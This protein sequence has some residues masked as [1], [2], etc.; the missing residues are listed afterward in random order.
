MCIRDS[1]HTACVPR[2]AKNIVTS[3]TGVKRP[4]RVFVV[5]KWLYCRGRLFSG[6][7]VVWKKGYICFF[8]VYRGFRLL[9][10]PVIIFLLFLLEGPKAL[11]GVSDD[12]TDDM[13]KRGI[14]TRKYE[15]AEKRLYEVWACLS[16]ENIC[17]LNSTHST[18][19]GG[20]SRTCYI[21]DTKYELWL[22]KR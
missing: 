4:L 18:S 12:S 2:M 15:Q 3:G 21:C 9:W 16:L 6:P 8:S 20:G 5:L 14:S 1:S 17:C 22:G 11:A 13:S 19:F 7:N 10:L